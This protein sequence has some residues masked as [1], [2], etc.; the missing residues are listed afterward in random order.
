MAK[1]V[2]ENCDNVA[3][4]TSSDPTYFAKSQDV[5]DKQ[6]GTGSIKVIAKKLIIHTDG[7]DN[8]NWGWTLGNAVISGGILD[9]AN[10]GYAYKAVSEEARDWTLEVNWKQHTTGVEG[11]QVE[12]WLSGDD[13]PMVFDVYD[14]DNKYRIVYD[15][16]MRAFQADWYPTLEYNY[17][18]RIRRV[19]TT[20]YF[21]VSE[22][23]TGNVEISWNYGT[24]RAPNKILL[25]MDTV[26]GDFDNFN[27][28]YTAGALNDTIIRDLGA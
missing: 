23:A 16:L 14:F 3:L 17:R 15:G 27:W 9:C 12:I 8:N 11:M 4:W 13:N 5:G 19:G 24:S 1:T 2:L 18:L 28:R 20:Y 6:E 21:R 7:F 25:L 26:V 10:D 22:I